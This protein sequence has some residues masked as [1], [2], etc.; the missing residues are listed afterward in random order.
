MP[1]VLAAL[2]LERFDESG[3][4][5]RRDEPLPLARRKRDDPYTWICGNAF[6]GMI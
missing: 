2:L 6:C 3:H 1:T 4:L 5:D